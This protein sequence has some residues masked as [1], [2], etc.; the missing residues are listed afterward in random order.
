MH[1][2]YLK[3]LSVNLKEFKR[4]ASDILSFKKGWPFLFVYDN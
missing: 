3:I 2:Q 1:S 4:K